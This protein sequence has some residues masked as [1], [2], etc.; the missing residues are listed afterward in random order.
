M[1]LLTHAGAGGAASGGQL[2]LYTQQLHSISVNH[3]PNPTPTCPN[4]T[5]PLYMSADCTKLLFPSGA[6]GLFIH[7]NLVPRTRVTY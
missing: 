7:T 1:L 6:C 2:A 5:L 3:S 4:P